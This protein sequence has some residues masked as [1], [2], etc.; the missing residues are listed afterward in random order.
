MNDFPQSDI[1]RLADNDPNSQ[2]FR[3]YYRFN[4]KFFDSAEIKALTQEY[5]WTNYMTGTR[6]LST[7]RGTLGDMIHFNEFCRESGIQSMRDLDNGLVD[8]YRSFL[9]LRISPST[10]RP[11]SYTSQGKCFST[12]KILVG[13]GQTF[14]PEAV[15]EKQ[16][17][18]GKEYDRVREPPKIK[19]IPDDILTSIN[20]ALKN[21]ENPYL[22]CGIIWNVQVCAL[23]IC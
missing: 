8:D 16:I 18:T 9:R 1:W 11:L 21:E 12:L 3:Q 20:Q 23:V 10:G 13:W 15:P 2:H 6:A 5:I 7:L 19:Y 17:F 22:K 14:H 4:F